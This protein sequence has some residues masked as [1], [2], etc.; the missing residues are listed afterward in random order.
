MK[1]KPKLLMV[2]TGTDMAYVT[3]NGV[4]VVPIGTLKD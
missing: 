1:I 4:L 2:I 3:P